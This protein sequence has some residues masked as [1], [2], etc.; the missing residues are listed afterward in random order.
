M[1]TILEFIDPRPYSFQSAAYCNL[2]YTAI[3]MSD[4]LLT[5]ED[6]NPISPPT[7]DLRRQSQTRSPYPPPRPQTRPRCSLT[8]MEAPQ[9]PGKGV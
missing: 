6:P 4:R 8:K 1:V 7:P 5:Q 9:L 2:I 3:Y